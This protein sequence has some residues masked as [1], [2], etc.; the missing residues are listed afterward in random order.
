MRGI[1][2]GKEDARVHARMRVN[3]VVKPAFGA[4][5]RSSHTLQNRD[6]EQ[7][8]A[9]RARLIE[10]TVAAVA[11]GSGPRLCSSRSWA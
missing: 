4:S 11:G 2:G 6:R 5:Q 3:C 9:L 7:T 10:A 1:I 8:E